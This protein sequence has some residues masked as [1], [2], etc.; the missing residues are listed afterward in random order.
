MFMDSRYFDAIGGIYTSSLGH[1]HPPIIEAAKAQLDQ[2]TFVPVTTLPPNP[3]SH[4]PL[5]LLEKCASPA[6]SREF[7]MPATFFVLL[8][9][10]QT[11]Y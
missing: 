3:P 1:Q 2:M 9:C 10:L 7:G 8:T 6:S 5:H 11:Q 4:P